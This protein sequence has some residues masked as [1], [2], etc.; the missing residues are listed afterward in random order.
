[1]EQV[2][3]VEQVMDDAIEGKLSPSPYRATARCVHG[4]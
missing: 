3:F 4:H 2:E 1:M